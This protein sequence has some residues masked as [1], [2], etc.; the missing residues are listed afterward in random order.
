MSGPVISLSPDLIV[1]T[2]SP[3]QRKRVPLG[4]YMSREPVA[5]W[6]VYR[7]D[8]GKTIVLEAIEEAA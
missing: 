6:R 8:S 5:A 2:V 3:D 4:R 7:L 1:G